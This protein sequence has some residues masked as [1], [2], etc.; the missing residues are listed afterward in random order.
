[1]YGK[2]ITLFLQPVYMNISIIRSHTTSIPHRQLRNC[3]DL[4]LPRDSRE[5]AGTWDSSPGRIPP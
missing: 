4:P 3:L 1:M 2:W 5:T